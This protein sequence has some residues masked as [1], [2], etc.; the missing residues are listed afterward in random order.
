MKES[1]ARITALILFLVALAINIASYA[2]L[3][4][5]LTIEMFGNTPLPTI[6]IQA[7]GL[8]VVLL[9]AFRT[10]TAQ[11]GSVR[12]QMAVVLGL[13]VAVNAVLVAMG[14]GWF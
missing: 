10:A 1:T 9:V 7:I 11:E 4:A 3:P 2:L 5:K 14:A 6:L 8:G 12:T 13:L